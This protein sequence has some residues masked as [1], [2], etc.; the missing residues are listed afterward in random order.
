MAPV[1]VTLRF[2]N[3]DDQRQ[4]VVAI[5]ELELRDVVIKPGEDALTTVL[6]I[7]VDTG[8][9]PLYKVNDAGE[10]ALSRSGEVVRRARERASLADVKVEASTSVWPGVG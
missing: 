9:Q 2:S 5:K 10:Q 7:E 6:R 8:G 3:Q 1:D 4:L